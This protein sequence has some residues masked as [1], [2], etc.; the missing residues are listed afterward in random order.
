MKEQVLLN[1]ATNDIAPTLLAGYC[2][3]GAATL[4]TGNYT[5]SGGGGNIRD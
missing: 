1:G 2:K 5:P 4:I 3:Y